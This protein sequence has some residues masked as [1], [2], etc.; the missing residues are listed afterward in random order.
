[1]D[2]AEFQHS[3]LHLKKSILADFGLVFYFAKSQ[4][5]PPRIRNKH[6]KGQQKFYGTT[7]ESTHLQET[8][9]LF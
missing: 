3:K 6:F 1:M 7:A 5:A 8:M 2:H 9:L 4:D